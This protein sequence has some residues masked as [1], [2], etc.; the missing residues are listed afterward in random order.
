LSDGFFL[1][2]KAPAD[3][4]PMV[5]DGTLSPDLKLTPVFNNQPILS[6]KG[7]RETAGPQGFEGFKLDPSD[8]DRREGAATES[9]TFPAA[10][11][12]LH[13]VVN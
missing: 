3:I 1:A 12:I 7:K 13:R 6:V 5:V 8:F 9:I 11:I 10:G 2:D 4:R